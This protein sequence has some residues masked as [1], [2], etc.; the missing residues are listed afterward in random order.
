MKNFDGWITNELP[1][2]KATE[3]EALGSLH[4]HA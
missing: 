3:A 4:C 2:G 1:S